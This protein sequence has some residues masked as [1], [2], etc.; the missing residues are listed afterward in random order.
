LSV[1]GD[2]SRVELSSQRR[3]AMGWLLLRHR[4]VIAAVAE[5]F[6]VRTSRISPSANTSQSGASPKGEQEPQTAL[7]I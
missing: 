6:L 4:Q 7:W 5:G 3:T 2:V 1:L